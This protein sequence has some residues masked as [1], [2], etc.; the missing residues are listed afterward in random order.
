MRHCARCRWSPSRPGSAEFGVAVVDNAWCSRLGQM[1]E[2]SCRRA[3]QPSR[4]FPG[5][6]PDWRPCLLL[7][8][9]LFFPL[10]HALADAPAYAVGLVVVAESGE[11]GLDQSREL[12]QPATAARWPFR[13]VLENSQGELPGQVF[14]AQ[15]ASF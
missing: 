5:C 14:G 1:G 15:C 4:I 13:L 8:R 2:T 7:I 10:A 3:P 12:C 6:F 11:L 9:V